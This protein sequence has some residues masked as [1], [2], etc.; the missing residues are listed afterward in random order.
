MNVRTITP[1]SIPGWSSTPY[2]LITDTDVAISG[3]S[4]AVQIPANDA[5]PNGA[6]YPAIWFTSN[7]QWLGSSRPGGNDPVAD[8]SQVM[9]FNQIGIMSGPAT[10]SGQPNT[11]GVVKVTLVV[12]EL[13]GNSTYYN[14]ATSATIDLTNAI[15]GQMYWSAPLPQQFSVYGQVYNGQPGL[16][17]LY[18]Y[19]AVQPPTAYAMY[20][21]R[22]CTL[23]N[24]AL[25]GS[26][27]FPAQ[28]G[29]PPV[30]TSNHDYMVG[31]DLNLVNYVNLGISPIVPTAALAGTL[32]RRGELGTPPANLIPQVGLTGVVHRAGTFEGINNLTV[33]GPILT[34][35]GGLAGGSLWKPAILCTG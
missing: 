5:G 30:I 28:P 11:T 25:W 8:A 17:Q 31:V 2:N 29:L 18:Y 24:G 27:G 23:R 4:Q 20:A 16:Q 13:Q 15:P 34:N 32:L 26:V 14:T 21:Q 35:P 1:T 22:S 33:G 10:F 9:Y 12:V 3:S 19:L 6:G 7:L